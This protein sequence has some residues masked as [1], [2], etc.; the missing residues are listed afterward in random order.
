MSKIER[1]MERKEDVRSERAEVIDDIFN[2]WVGI[3]GWIGWC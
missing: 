1:R 2:A 3:G